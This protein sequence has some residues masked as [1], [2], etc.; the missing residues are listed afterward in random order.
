MAIISLVYLA[1]ADCSNCLVGSLPNSIWSYA[2]RAVGENPKAVDTAGLSVERSALQRHYLVGGI[3]CGI[4]G[5][6]ICN[7]IILHNSQKR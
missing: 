5:A 6:Y 1:F 4:G 3:L 7:C 2:L